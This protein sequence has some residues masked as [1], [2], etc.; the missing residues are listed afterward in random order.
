MKRALL[1][2]LLDKTAFC[3]SGRLFAIRGSGR[4]SQLTS[5]YPRRRCAF[6]GTSG[7]Y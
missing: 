6:L 1:S 7:F 5:T 4:M 2:V 3:P